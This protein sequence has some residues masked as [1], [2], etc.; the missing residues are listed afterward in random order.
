MRERVDGG[1]QQGRAPARSPLT[2]HPPGLA[3]F[4]GTGCSLVRG[5]SG[6]FPEQQRIK[7]AGLLDFVSDLFISLC[8]AGVSM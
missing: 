7:C 8:L 2:A 1:H 4:R 6:L 5:R 3:R